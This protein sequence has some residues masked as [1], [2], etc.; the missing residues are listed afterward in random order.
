MCQKKETNIIILMVIT[1][2]FG[3]GFYTNGFVTTAFRFQGFALKGPHKH[4]KASSTYVTGEEISW[5]DRDSNLGPLAYRARTL[6][7]EL[8]SHMVVLC[9]FPLLN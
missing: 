5:P 6:Q 3:G 4:R 8:P 1:F 7:T 9:H 2:F